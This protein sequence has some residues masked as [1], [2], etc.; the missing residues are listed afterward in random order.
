MDCA[1]LIRSRESVRSYDPARSLDREVLLRILE[2]GRLAP[3]AAN[4]Q[5]WQF[6]V[7]E[8]PETLGKVRACYH[9]EWF[10]K[11]PCV[12]VVTG[13][14]DLAWKRASDGY[15]SIETDL[16]IAMDHMI[17]TAENEGVGACWIAAFDP[18]VLRQ[19]LNL[20]HDTCL[21]AITPLGYPEAAYSKKGT[22]TRKPMDEVVTFV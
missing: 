10:H 20:P 13:S 22:K 19:A 8:H 3:S 14:R 16:A 18:V 1:E 15:C 11:A 17:L 9:R 21:F 2:A 7:V 6:I 5:P 12:L 4:R